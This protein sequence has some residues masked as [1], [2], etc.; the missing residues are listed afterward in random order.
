VL[1]HV[2]HSPRVEV[3]IHEMDFPEEKEVDAKLLKLCRALDARLYTTDYNLGKIAEIQ[4]VS[5]VNLSELAA[6]LK[7]SVLPGDPLT[8]KI[9]REGREKG[10][11]VAYLGDGTM[12]VVNGAASLVGQQVN[13]QV[14]SLLQTG[15]GVIVFAEL[16][17]SA[18]A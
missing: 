6:L 1:M 7:P 2:R 17:L 14:Q 11:G 13:V 12:V 15:A 16:R 18:A 10:Q 5:H 9:T 8:L 3:R 4:A